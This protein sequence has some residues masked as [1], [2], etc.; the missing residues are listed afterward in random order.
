[1]ARHSG[2]LAA[3]VDSSALGRIRLVLL[4]SDRLGTTDLNTAM[5]QAD[6]QIASELLRRQ[7]EQKK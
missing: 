6:E 4:T 3:I 7:Q 1:M 5:R 2:K